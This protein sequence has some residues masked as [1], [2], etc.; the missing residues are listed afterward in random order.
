MNSSIFEEKS[1]FLKEI[2]DTINSQ[3][4]DNKLLSKILQELLYPDNETNKYIILS[5]GSKPFY[6][7]TA[8]MV[9]CSE[10][11]INNATNRYIK[12][13]EEE[14]YL[15]DTNTLKSYLCL[16]TILHEIMHYYQ[17]NNSKVLTKN[18][19]NYLSCINDF[20]TDYTSFLK[21]DYKKSFNYKF[22]KYKR[23]EYN[24]FIERNA[25]VEALYI[26][27]NI[28]DLNKNELINNYISNF[29]LAYENI[30]YNNN[31]GCIYNTYKKTHRLKYFKK[32]YSSD[33]IDFKYKVK[34]GLPLNN[35]ECDLYINRIK[36]IKKKN[37]KVLKNTSFNY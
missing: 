7:M 12:G 19:N 21:S 20:Y 27:K 2:V 28:C 17:F 5:L 16:F 23:N 33:K 31:H 22:K 32:I 34:Y 14:F 37:I 30:G 3:G 29:I 24:Y 35:K 4:L 11:G 25:S 1:I 8:N 15:Y 36:E 13:L 26:L 9:V 18:D 10:K 6:S